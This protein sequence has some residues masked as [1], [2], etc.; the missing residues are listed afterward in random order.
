MAQT[1]ATEHHE[2]VVEPDAIDLAPILARQYGEPYADSSA[3]PTYCLAELASKE[4][5]VALNGDGGDES[6]AGYLRHPANSL[7]AWV[8][9]LPV[10]PRRSLAN[11]A[12]RAWTRG[13]DVA[14][15]ST[16][17]AT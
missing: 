11:L 3:L 4:V 14:R 5:T 12:G 7:T 13:S 16:H 1:F 17:A 8:D 10:G 2:F 9:H 15:G 6:F